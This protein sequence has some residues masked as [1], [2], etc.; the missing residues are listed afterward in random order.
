M[1]SEFSFSKTSCLT[2][3]KEPSLPYYLPIAGGWIIGFIPFPRILVLCEMQSVSSRIWTRVA[4]SISYDDD[5]YTM[6]TSNTTTPGQGEPGSNSYEGVLHTFQISRTGSSLSYSGH[7][8][9]SG[10]LPLYVGYSL[11]ILNPLTEWSNHL[12][13]QKKE[14]LC[15][16]VCVCVCMHV[17]A[18]VCLHIKFVIKITAVYVSKL[19]IWNLFIFQVYLHIFFI[20][21]N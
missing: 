14:T 21:A 4:V 5:H 16:C 3:A 19:S 13:K 1:N 12:C 9:F 7:S 10:V 17:R 8:F 20:L 6:G 18:C 2:K 15:V 11:W